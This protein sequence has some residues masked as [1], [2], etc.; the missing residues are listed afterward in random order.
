MMLKLF[1]SVGLIGTSFLLN[2][3][4]VTKKEEIQNS[5][6]NEKYLKHIKDATQAFKKN[7]QFAKKHNQKPPDEYYL[8][9]FIATMDPE[10][11]KVSNQNYVELDKRVESGTYRPEK[12]LKMFNGINSQYSS[13]NINSLWVERGPY[14][15]GGRVRGIMFDPNDVTGKKVWAG[16][17]SGGLWY[18]NDITNATSEWV[19]VDGFWSN[20]TVSC[21]VSDPNNSQ[22]FYVGTGEVETGDFSGLGIWKTTDGGAT[23]QQIFNIENGYASNGV[24]RGIYNVPDIQVV[25]NNGVSEVYAGVAGTYFGDMSGNVSFVGVYEAG[26]YKSTDGINFTLLNS[27]LS[28]TTQGYD[29]QDIEVGTDNSIW[30]STRPSFVGS[31]SSGGK[32][33]K[34]TD[35]GAT[36]T[37]VY[38][39]GN[40]NSRV[41]VEVSN[42]NSLKAYAL[43]QGATNAEPVR[44]L[45]TVDGGTTWISTDVAVSG[46]TLPNPI[47]TGQPDNDFTRGQAFYDLVIETDPQNDEHVYVGGIDSYKSTDGGATWTQ[48]TKWSNNN[49]LNAA[50][51]AGVHADQHA[52]VF[53]PKN[54]NQF[55]MGNDGGIF[56][57]ADKNNLANN[58]AIGVRNKRLNITQFYHGTLNPTATFAN[59]NMILGAQDNGTRRLSGVPLANNF[60]TSSEVYGG[61]GAYTAYD[62]QGLYHIASYVYNNHIIFNAQGA[63]NLLSSSTQRNAGQFINPLAVDR[64]L[65]IAYTN[66]N[67]SSSTSIILNRISGLAS[68]PLSLTRTQLTIAAVTAGEFATDIFVS[69]YTTASSTLFIGLSSG[70]LF[71]VTNANATHSTSQINFDF[72]GYISDIKLGASESE[73]MVTVSNFNKTSVFYSIN[74]GT[75]WVSKE[76]NLP[77]IPVKA[78]FMNP[79]DNNEVIL[80]TYFGVWGTANF[81]TTSPTWALYSDGLGKFKVNHFDYRASDKTILAVTY[82]RGAFTT[83]IDNTTLATNETQ[84]N[85]VANQVYPNP[86]RGSLHVKLANGKP[87]D[88][89]IFDVSGKLV[90]TKKNIK[91]DEEFNIENLI[92]GDYVLKAIQN[93]NIVYTSVIIRK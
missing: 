37:N 49:L 80:G 27:L 21:I 44:I 4:E 2:A 18:N 38:D 67:S 28:T 62:D 36:F 34:S 90:I 56:F 74:G 86:T 84:Q 48:Y 3:Q 43:L 88:I 63:Y 72:G 25:N 14:E 9:D 32:I 58:S 53:N 55:V 59:E 47:D 35:H 68:V 91:S 8:Q 78:I 20:T 12:K 42:T 5:K 85:S 33:F 66:A 71:K 69:P 29:I 16:G 60:Y 41:M 11:G 54:L 77:D 57:A 61:D 15:V 52:L 24:K 7:V 40:K 23:W 64:N 51:I 70:K 17:V 31:S 26:L 19:L 45:K 46:I 87:V 6:A 92:K 10:T 50:N 81:Q 65:D 89:E 22:I 93:G 83:K 13:K 30:V 75:T 73:I 1:L 76:G 82:G 39:V 79:E